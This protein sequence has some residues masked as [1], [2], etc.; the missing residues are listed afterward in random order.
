[1]AHC[2]C[3]SDGGSVAYHFRGKPA[4]LWRSTIEM[5]ESHHATVTQTGTRDARHVGAYIYISIETDTE[6][7]VFLRSGGR[8]VLREVNCGLQGDLQ[9]LGRELLA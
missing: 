4:R 5:F 9:G 1:M 8:K 7:V 2:A 3:M 6:G